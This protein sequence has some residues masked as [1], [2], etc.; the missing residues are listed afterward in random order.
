MKSLAWWLRVVGVFY[1]LQFVV[2]VVAKAPIKAQGPAGVLARAA[3]GDPTARFL[4]DTWVT[5]AL[6]VGAIGAV[7]LFASRMPERAKILVWA[8]IAIEFSRGIVADVYVITRGEPLNVVVPWLFIH[9][10][11]IVSGLLVLRPDRSAPE[12]AVAHARAH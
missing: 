9:T 10:V 8:I 12:I 3:A 11:V 5:F 7:L 4:V 1:V 6:E 2:I